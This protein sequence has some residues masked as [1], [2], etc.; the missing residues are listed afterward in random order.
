MNKDVRCA[1]PLTEKID[2][3]GK[4]KDMSLKK[5]KKESEPAVA[6]DESSTIVSFTPKAKRL[7]HFLFSLSVLIHLLS[8]LFLLIC[9]MSSD[10]MMFSFGVN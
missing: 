6:M 7:S 4:D 1:S 2:N 10:L 3:K 9:F 8:L 5:D